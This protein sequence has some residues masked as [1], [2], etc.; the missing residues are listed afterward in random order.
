MFICRRKHT[1]MSKE[2]EAKL[3]YGMLFSLKSFS[4]KL[5]PIDMKQGFTSYKTNVYRLSLYETPSSLKFVLNT[6]NEA[7]QQEV[8]LLTYS[9]L[10][11]SYLLFSTTFQIRELLSGLYCQVYVEFASKSPML[12]PGE[13]ITSNLFRTKL[14][15]FMRAS[16]IFR[17]S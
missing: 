4:A 7:S 12:V 9:S 11:S 15:Q 14:D 2:E 17:Q 5:S 3:L 8:S 6:D 13:M 1:S 16:S 10:K